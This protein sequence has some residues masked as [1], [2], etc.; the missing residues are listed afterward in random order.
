LSCNHEWRAILFF[1]FKLL[2]LSQ[3]IH[4]HEREAILFFFFKLLWLSQAI[5]M[6][7]EP[8]YSFF[9]SFYGFL[10]PSL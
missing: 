7:G 1:F 3:A 2:W 9:S 6:S 5:I 10:K 8:F 4:H